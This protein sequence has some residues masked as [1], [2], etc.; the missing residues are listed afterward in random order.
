[1][2]ETDREADDPILRR[3]EEL[4]RRLDAED[5][6]EVRDLEAALREQ[7]RERRLARAA[8]ADEDEVR[9]LEVARLLAVVALDG[10]LDRLDPAEVL[11]GEREHRARRVD[12][13]PI[14]EDLELADERADQIERFDLELVARRV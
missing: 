1:R 9:L 6:R 4:G 8:H 3:L 12:R 13:L 11:V 10:E 5:D 7:G 2:V 14:E